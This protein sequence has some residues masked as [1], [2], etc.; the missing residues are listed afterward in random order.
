M[1]EQRS[2]KTSTL[3]SFASFMHPKELVRL[4]DLA[5]AITRGRTAR[6]SM[7][8]ILAELKWETGLPLSRRA[9]KARSRRGPPAAAELGRRE[10]GREDPTPPP[11]G[12]LPLPCTPRPLRLP[13]RRPQFPPCSCPFRPRTFRSSWLP[14]R[15]SP[16]RRFARSAGGWAPTS[17]CPSFCLRRQFGAA[18]GP[19][20]RARSSR[21]WSGRSGSRSTV[22]IRMPWRRPPAS[23]PSTISPSSSTSTSAAR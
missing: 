11:G 17:C 19:R 20:W 2:T 7:T 21:R 3:D 14:W 13:L 18:F 10:V 5:S 22:P 4:A 16:R 15:E 8:E 6:S 12:L 9:P 1:R 23:S